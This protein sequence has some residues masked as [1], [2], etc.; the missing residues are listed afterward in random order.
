MQSR[1]SCAYSYC[2][3]FSIFLRATPINDDVSC[4]MYQTNIF[5]RL[6]LAMWAYRLN[7]LFGSL[8][9]PAALAVSQHAGRAVSKRVHILSNFSPTRSPAVLVFPHQSV[10]AIFL[11]GPPPPSNGD[12]ECRCGMKNSDFDQYLAL[13]RK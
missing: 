1:A 12:V 9:G 4:E 13:S 3:D 11:L 7:C 10:I 2:T 6:T 8:E 5:M